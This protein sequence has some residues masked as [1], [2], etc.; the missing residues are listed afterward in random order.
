MNNIKVFYDSKNTGGSKYVCELTDKLNE[1][2]NKDNAFK[3]CRNSNEPI[4]RIEYMGK[5]VADFIVEGNILVYTIVKSNIYLGTIGIIPLF[6]ST[7]NVNKLHRIL[8]SYKGRKFI[9]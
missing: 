9:Y 7:S 8:E 6:K 2:F 1:E 4:I 3:L 5:S